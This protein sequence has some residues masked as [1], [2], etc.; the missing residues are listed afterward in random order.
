V[1]VVPDANVVSRDGALNF[2]DELDEVMLEGIGGA[3]VELWTPSEAFT[4]F[5]TFTTKK[6]F[7][8]GF[9]FGKNRNL[10]LR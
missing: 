4:T 9:T 7:E 6:A 5:I 2:V 3:W 1:T 8:Y 10:L